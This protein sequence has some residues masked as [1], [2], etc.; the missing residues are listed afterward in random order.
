MFL[1]PKDIVEEFT[2]EQTRKCR[3]ARKRVDQIYRDMAK[4]RLDAKDMDHDGKELEH[5]AEKHLN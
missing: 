1:L 2:G 3:D 4:Q 5:S